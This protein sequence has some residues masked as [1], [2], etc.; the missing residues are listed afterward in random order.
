MK[1]VVFVFVLAATTL[2]IARPMAQSSAPAAKP[3][4]KPAAAGRLVEL[5]AHMTPAGK[6]VYEPST[7]TAKP[8]EQLHVRLKSTGTPMPKMAMAH[9]FVVVKPKTDLTK[10]TADAI[11]AGFPANFVPAGRKTDII[12]SSPLAGVGDTVDVSFKAPAA[13]TYPFLCTFPGHMAGGMKG[14]LVVK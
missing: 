8:G 7:I 5:T 2:W 13:G 1:R 4:A 9:N 11:A 12:V 3:A 10:F 14:S 6:Y